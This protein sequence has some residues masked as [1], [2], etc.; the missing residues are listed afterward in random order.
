VPIV[1]AH[2]DSET[3]QA[4]VEI[5]EAIDARQPGGIVKSLPLVS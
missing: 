3:A 5:A 1:A 2:P 4:I